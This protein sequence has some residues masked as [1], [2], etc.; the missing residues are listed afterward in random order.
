MEL[1]SSY[2]TLILILK[3]IFILLA[4]TH[5]YLQKKGEENTNL[6]D[7]IVYWKGA[8]ELLFKLLLSLLLIF[9]FNP[10][11]TSNS[12]VIT[13][14]TKLLLFLF[15]GALLITAPWKNIMSEYNWLQTLQQSV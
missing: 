15:G 6:D 2:T 3:F 9:L 11:Y 4:I 10:I 8:V 5:I 12:V 14:E 13:G 7:K 1:Y